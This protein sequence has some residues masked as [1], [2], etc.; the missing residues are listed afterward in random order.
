MVRLAE[1]EKQLRSEVTK[2][3][4]L[5]SRV[6]PVGHGKMK[7]PLSREEFKS[8]IFCQLSPM[9]VD[10]AEDAKLDVPENAKLD[11]AE[12]AKDIARLQEGACEPTYDTESE[13]K[14]KDSKKVC[15]H[16]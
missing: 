6:Q 8:L 4:P 13:P 11:V 2:D 9:T 1:M 7:A 12:K 14:A 16:D 15:I 10:E 3:A 5:A